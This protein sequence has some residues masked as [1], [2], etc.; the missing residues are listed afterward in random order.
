MRNYFYISI[1]FFLVSSFWS[2][3]RDITI[4]R[5]VVDEKGKPLD[6]VLV[7]KNIK[8]DRTEYLFN[9]YTI[10]DE[11]GQFEV[12]MRL[13]KDEIK[14][15]SINTYLIFKKKGGILSN[16]VKIQVEKRDTIKLNIAVFENN[17]N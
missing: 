13:E 14:R 9:Q 1:L 4:M 11:G 12:T 16:K 2:L 15:D 7:G 8:I 10:T 17:N 5:T 6:Q 3:N